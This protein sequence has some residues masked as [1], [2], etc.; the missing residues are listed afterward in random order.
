MCLPYQTSLGEAGNPPI[1]DFDQMVFYDLPPR[2]EAHEILG[3]C[4]AKGKT[5]SLAARLSWTLGD[6]S[7]SAWQVTGEELMALNG[8]VVRDAS[9]R[10][11]MYIIRFTQYTKE[12]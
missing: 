8:A 1:K 9:R 6:I 11:P 5:V 4:E 3:I 2:L 10:Q 7:L 12:L